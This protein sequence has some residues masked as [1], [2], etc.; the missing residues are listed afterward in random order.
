M[1]ENVIQLMDRKKS[2]KA[3]LLNSICHKTHLSLSLTYKDTILTSFYIL[4][5]FL[6]HSGWINYGFKYWLRQKCSNSMV[7]CLLI[8]NME[9]MK[10]TSQRL[11]WGFLLLYLYLH[12]EKW[13]LLL[14]LRRKFWGKPFQKVKISFWS[15]ERRKK[16]ARS[17]R[18]GFRDISSVTQKFPLK[19]KMT[20]ENEPWL[21][22]GPLDF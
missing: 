20:S 11:L 18:A 12:S 4:F 9:V 15:Q 2:K 16:F 13:P 19:M 8:Y 1:L 14:L 10:L 22:D 7:L 6:N 21:R 3:G 17:F 5:Y